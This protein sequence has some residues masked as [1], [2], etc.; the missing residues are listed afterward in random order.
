MVDRM[1]EAINTEIVCVGAYSLC[2]GK[3]KKQI[4]ESPL[5]C[6]KVTNYAYLKCNKAINIDLSI[7]KF[8]TPYI[9]KHENKRYP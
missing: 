8:S 5:I 9:K 4:T 3:L 6:D 7:W 1:P 2:L